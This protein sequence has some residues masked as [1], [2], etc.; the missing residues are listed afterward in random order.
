[1]VRD[2]VRL[3]T[4]DSEAFPFSFGC[5]SKETNLFYDQIA[6]GILGLGMGHGLGVQEQA[7]IYDAIQRA[8]VT[9]SKMFSL[10][11]GKN[12]GFLEMGGFNSEKFLSDVF[13]LE[14]L[15]KGTGYEF[16]VLSTSMNNHEIAGSE[17]WSVGFVDSGTTFS[18]FPEAMWD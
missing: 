18:Y 8:E 10:C 6:D 14:M 4:E 17:K 5:V 7:P 16:S 2:E 9:D 3:S 1:M 15:R 12:G 13:W 11:L